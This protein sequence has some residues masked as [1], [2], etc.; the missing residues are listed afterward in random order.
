MSQGLDRLSRSP[1][2]MLHIMARIERGGTGFRSLTEAIDTTA[3]AG[4]KMRM[5]GSFAA[6]E[7]ALIRERAGGRRRLAGKQ[8][9][10]IAGYVIPGSKFGAGMARL[11]GVSEPTVSRIV[12]AYRQ[13]QGEA[14]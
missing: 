9:R 8:R 10:E 13:Q 4:R 1:K 3:A 6:F 7:R 14:A 11:R 12:A 5:V 2:D